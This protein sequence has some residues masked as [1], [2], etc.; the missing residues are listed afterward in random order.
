MTV[1]S[2]I[3]SAL[4]GPEITSLTE[5]LI[6]KYKVLGFTLFSRNIESAKQLKKLNQDLQKIAAKAGYKLILAV[7]QEGGRVARLK[8]PEFTKIPPM[9]D[10]G[11]KI[12]NG[13][14]P[15]SVFK[16]GEALAKE[17]ASV[18]FNL[19]FAPVLDINSNPENPIIGDRSFSSDPRVVYQCAKQILLAFKKHRIISCVKHFPGHGDTTVDSH[20]DLP[21]D[22]RPQ[23]DFENCDLQPYKKLIEENL[24]QSLMTAHV[25]YPE[26][27][28]EHP[29]TL[30]AKI[31]DELLRK[32]MGYHGIIFSDDLF[33]NAI[34]KHHGTQNAVRDFF[35]CGGDVA[36]LCEQPQQSK[37]VIEKL[38]KDQVVL[39]KL[40]ISKNRL[41]SI[42]EFIQ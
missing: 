24:V 7:D 35:L 13:E 41:K 6:L 2:H 22:Q 11:Q 15:D 20:L 31:I 10:Y 38:Q 26:W 1:G 16:M 42:L 33:M 9:A 36:L 39:K 28:K 25:V 29:A 19:D 32:R 23:C 17:V 4:D 34:A 14:S 30:S 5:E 27:D 18:G 40:N 37:E 8:A 12:A 21:Y 3:L